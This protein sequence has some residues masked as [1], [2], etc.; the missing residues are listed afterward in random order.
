MMELPQT[1]I[2]TEDIRP[3]GPVL[4]FAARIRCCVAYSCVFSPPAAAIFSLTKKNTKLSPKRTFFPIIAFY[5]LYIHTRRNNR[6]GIRKR[7][8]VQTR[9]TRDEQ[10]QI[11]RTRKINNSLPRRRKYSAC[12]DRIVDVY[13]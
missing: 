11:W 1:P 6:K 10:L 4:C 12:C 2:K 9:S 5:P 7:N 3:T 8:S 13:V